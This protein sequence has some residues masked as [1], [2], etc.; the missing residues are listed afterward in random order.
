[1]ATQTLGEIPLPQPAGMVLK[2]TKILRIVAVLTLLPTG[3]F[4]GFAAV[5]F[6]QQ[7]VPSTEGSAICAIAAA[8]AVGTL[9]WLFPLESAL[10][11]RLTAEG[12]E[13]RSRQGQRRIQWSAVRE[14]WIRAVGVQAGGLLG[15]AL[16]AAADASRKGPRAGLSEASTN[17]TIRIVG[18]DSEIAL[19]SNY[20]GVVAAMEEVLANVN[21]RLLAEAE[22]LVK[23]GQTVAFGKIAVSLKGVAIGRK[24]PI[25]F[26]EI[27]KLTVDNGKVYLKKRGS[28]LSN[29]AGRAEKIPNLY[30]LT[31]LCDA[32]SGGHARVDT[33]PDQG[34]AKRTTV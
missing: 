2:R 34:L 27:E 17:I 18:P 12:I 4:F 23:G 29:G 30:V 16:V 25:P 31:A 7:K 22:R 1:M 20:H 21:P 14:I 3:V 9:L 33:A 32:L 13:E 28:W 26:A 6:A 11:L 5:S 24:E 15:A 10:E 19:T 8:A